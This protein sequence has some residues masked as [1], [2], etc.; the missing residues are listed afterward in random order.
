SPQAG[1]IFEPT[2]DLTFYVAYAKGFRPNS[3]F[4]V[5]RNPFAPEK[6]ESAEVGVK[7][8]A[9]DGHVR[10]TLAAYTMK[11]TN[12]ITA[13]PV[14]QGFSLAIGKAKSRG[15]ELDTN[16]D[17]PGGVRFQFAYAYTDAFSAAD[18]REP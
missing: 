11:K 14:N 3:G 16:G 18:V 15:V 8:E 1:I 12:V 7:F 2:R 4:D 6:T 5:R 10:G 17:L 13:D 9:L